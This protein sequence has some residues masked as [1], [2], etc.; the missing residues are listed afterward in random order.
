LQASQLT[1]RVI[2]VASGGPEELELQASQLTRRVV[3]V[4]SGG[5]E[6]VDGGGGRRRKGGPWEGASLEDHASMEKEMGGRSVE[7]GD[8]GQHWG[9][10]EGGRRKR[11]RPLAACGSSAMGEIGERLMLL[12][13]CCYC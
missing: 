2:V 11:E 13:R 4:A 3:A 10:A 12:L 1:R 5:P 7:G 8:Q 9:G 6:Q